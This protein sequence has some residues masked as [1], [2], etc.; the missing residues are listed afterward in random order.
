MAK[1]GRHRRYKDA[2]E[3]KERETSIED[4]DLDDTSF[5]GRDAEERDKYEDLADK[6]NEPEEPADS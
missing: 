4:M 2:R 5:F 6:Y 1:K 3:F